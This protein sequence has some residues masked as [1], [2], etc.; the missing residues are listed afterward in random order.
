M[1]IIGVGMV[2]RGEPSFDGDECFEGFAVGSEC[3]VGEREHA[4][5]AERVG[6]SRRVV[7][8][9]YWLLGQV[10]RSVRECVGLVIWVLY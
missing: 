6:S 9:A 3:Q 7:C 4:C 5:V 8:S 1:A 2:G 10:R